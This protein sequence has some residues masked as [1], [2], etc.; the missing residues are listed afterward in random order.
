M[1]GVETSGQPGAHIKASTY[2]FILSRGKNLSA[3]CPDPD[4]D[5]RQFGE[6]DP[7]EMSMKA[8]KVIFFPL[9]RYIGALQLHDLHNPSTKVH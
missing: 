8:R 3:G 2:R 4:P 9:L 1:W 5:S 6:S 7:G